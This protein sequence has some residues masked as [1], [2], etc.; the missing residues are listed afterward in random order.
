MKLTTQFIK[1]RGLIRPTVLLDELKV[2]K[3]IEKM[4]IKANSAGVRLRPHFK[5]HQSIEIGR[6]FR[7]TG[8]EAI[9]V[10][11]LS[12]ANYFAADGWCDI[13][14]AILVNRNEINLINSL[15]DKIN[16]NLVVD[17]LDTIRFLE[18]FVK[19]PVNVLIKVDTGL[20]RTGVVWDN[21]K[22]ITSLV[23]EIQS[24]NRIKFLG[25]LTHSGQSYDAVSSDQIREI[26]RETVQRMNQ[27]KNIILKE[28]IDNCLL[29]IGD[30][31]CCS[32]VDDFS[33]VDEI[34]PGNYV[35]YDL[36]MHQIGVCK[37]EEI[38]VAVACPVVGKY[39]ERGEIIIYGG[40]VHFSKDYLLNEAG[41]KVF[42]YLTRFDG[43][44]W[45]SIEKSVY[46]KSLS[47]EHGKVRV[48]QKFMDEI[49]VGDFLLFL[50]VHSC[51][52]SD[53]YREYVTLD[54]K[55]ISRFNSF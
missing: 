19:H 14:V 35:F 36:K 42:G 21:T 11:S 44:S 37:T 38:A 34:R 20:G 49:E 52:T 4:R 6:W 40:A 17:H 41:E 9:A 33:G 29:S 31:P 23:R 26:H 24:A 16:L 8:T 1:S 46:I 3:N 54:G 45:H 39:P 13:T 53:L 12:M 50:P 32:V 22:L 25:L 10:S 28:G 27:V 55:H 2:K 18:N 48:D 15:A 43:D 51:L 47:Q 7:A 5:T 30:T